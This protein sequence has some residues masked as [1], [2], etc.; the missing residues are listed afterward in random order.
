M[1]VHVVDVADD[2]DGGG[3]KAIALCWQNAP[4]K[5]RKMDVDADFAMALESC[6]R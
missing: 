5:I 3:A 2:D 1:L 4:R 6:N